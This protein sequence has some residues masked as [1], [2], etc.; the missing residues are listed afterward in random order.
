MRFYVTTPDCSWTSVGGKMQIRG[1][2]AANCGWPSVG[3]S[4]LGHNGD[5]ALADS[6]LGK[7]GIGLF[8]FSMNREVASLLPLYYAVIYI[9][10]NREMFRIPT[11]SLDFS[12]LLHWAYQLS[13]ANKPAAAWAVRN[14]RVSFLTPKSVGIR[15]PP[16]CVATTDDGKS[17]LRNGS[18]RLRGSE[19]LTAVAG[20]TL[21]S[22]VL[23]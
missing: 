22:A 23:E 17:G 3:A 1:A 18:I 13:R 11:Q 12:T 6:G 5:T 21:P 9:F 2:V 8:F 14:S 16:S 20:S 15:C 4:S 7:R 10:S 19:L